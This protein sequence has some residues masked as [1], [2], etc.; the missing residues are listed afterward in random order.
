M[1]APTDQRRMAYFEW[2]DRLNLNVQDM[3][4]EH[5]RLIAAMNHIYDLNDASAPHEAIK[6]AVGVLQDVTVQ[7][8]AHEEKLMESMG[9]PKLA[10][11]KLIHKALLTDFSKHKAEFEARRGKMDP[12]FFTFLKGWLTAHIAGID[13]QYAA[14]SQGARKAG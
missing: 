14:H 7:H 3:D 8:F 2:S 12:A 10:A 1:P 4:A 13:K 5:K 11:H 6:K 9:F